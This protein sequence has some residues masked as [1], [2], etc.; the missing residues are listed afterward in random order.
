MRVLVTGGAGFIGRAVQRRI[1]AAG[2]EAVVF[3][4]ALDGADDIVDVPRLRAALRGCEA[5]IHLAAKV[6]LGVDLSDLDGYARDNDLGTAAVLRAAAEES[7]GR[8][9]L[10]SSM[11]V[12]GEGRARC[13]DHGTIPVPPR[14][15]GDLAAGRFEPR[16]P[17]CGTDLVPELVPEDTRLDPRNVYAATKVH[18]EQLAAIWARETGGTAVA[19]RYHNVYGPGL[20]HDT[21]YAGVAAIFRSALVAGRPPAVFEDGRQRRDFVHVDDVARATVAAVRAG[22]PAGPTALNIGSGHVVTIGEVASRMAMIMNGPE[23]VI[24]GRYRLG[25]VRHITA[26]SSTARRLL[27]WA[28]A[29]PLDQGLADLL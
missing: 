24:T 5:I 18:L 27:G 22:L 26:D 29:V 28:P 13:P 14:A 16:C 2:H 15:V 7:I 6:G 25:D 9:V 11:V 12:Y 23:P 21:P 3:D 8:V 1:D 17:R 19:L 4:R 20:P 10:A